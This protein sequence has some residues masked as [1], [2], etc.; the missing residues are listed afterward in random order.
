LGIPAGTGAK[1]TGLIHLSLNVAALVVFAIN[2]F[3]YVGR[4]DD[5]QEASAT[6]GIV[7]GLIGVGLTVAAGF[8]GW[9]LIQDHHVGVRLSPEQERL[10]PG[11]GGRAV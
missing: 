4:W 2:F 11:A 7:L 10:E 8:Q 3:A 5:P 9:K 1:R 6:L